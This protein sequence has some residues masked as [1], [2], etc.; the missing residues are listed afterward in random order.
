[1]PSLCGN[2]RTPYLHN[3][4]KMKI[5]EY[6]ENRSVAMIQFFKMYS[7]LTFLNQLIGACSGKSPVNKTDH[8]WLCFSF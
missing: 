2:K 5:K 8:R 3:Y 6:G 4:S 7:L 1:M